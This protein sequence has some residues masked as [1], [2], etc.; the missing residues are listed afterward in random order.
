MN[1]KVYAGAFT[2][3]KNL[4]I[5]LFL[6]LFYHLFNSCR[7]DSAVCNQLMQSKTR[8]F[9]AYRVKCREEDCLRSIIYHNL[10]SGGSLK[11]TD[12]STLTANDS[13]LNLIIVYVE[14]G[15][16]ILN[17]NLRSGTLDSV[18]Y[19]SLSLLRCTQAGLIHNIVDVSLGV[20]SGLCS[21]SLNKVFLSLVC[22]HSR[23]VLHLENLLLTQLFILV[24][25]LGNE[26]CLSLKVVADSLNFSLLAAN[27]VALLCE[28]QF[29][30]LNLVLLLTNLIVLVVYVLLV[31]TLE[32]QEFLFSL[33]NF[34]LLN[35]LSG[36]FSLL[37]DLGLSALE[38]YRTNN[39]ES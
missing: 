7:V 1:T 26:F 9:S 33:E 30:L 21:H 31:F 15:Y 27:L 34:L 38:N 18:D 19:Y 36:L 20:C 29:L 4:V 12:V 3:F 16:G 37:K 22:A 23:N 25:L 10:N 5:K 17:C 28:N 14:D 13:T 35:I 11:G 32:L 2:C 6:Y 8:N 24:Y 39:Y